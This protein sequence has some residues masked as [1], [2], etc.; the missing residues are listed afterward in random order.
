M[1]AGLVL[2]SWLVSLYFL[3]SFTAVNAKAAPA[4]GKKTIAASMKHML[5]SS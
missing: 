5:M 4:I 1:V 3:Y 2:V